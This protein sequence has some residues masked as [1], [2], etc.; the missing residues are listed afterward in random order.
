MRSVL[1]V[2][3][4]QREL[5]DRRFVIHGVPQMHRGEPGDVAADQRHETARVPIRRKARQ[6]RRHDVGLRGI[7]QLR[8]QPGKGFGVR[9]GGVA[10]R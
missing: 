1:L 2:D 5:S 9:G 6:S 3:D 8:A 4:E 10:Y 7:S